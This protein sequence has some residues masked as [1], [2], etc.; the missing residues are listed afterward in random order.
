MR[1]LTRLKSMEGTGIHPTKPTKPGFVGFV[2]TPSGALENSERH[3][4]AANDSARDPDRHCWPHSS[5]MNSTEIDTM[6]SRLALFANRGLNE[7][8]ADLLADDLKRRDREQGDLH[9]CLECVRL[10]RRG[11]CLAAAAGELPGADSRLEP[12][13]T[14]LMRCE[15][16]KLRK[17]L[18]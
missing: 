18:P 10:D 15:A 5:A 11:R 4:E 13:V 14:I 1:W 12:V 7:R 17:D 6:Q 16:F 9:L 8:D 3:G 2:G